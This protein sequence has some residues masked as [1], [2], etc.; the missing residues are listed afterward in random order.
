MPLADTLRRRLRAARGL[1]DCDLLIRNVRYLDVFS[2]AFVEGDVA[3]TSL[4][5]RFPDLALAGT[6]TIRARFTLR[7]RDHLP[8]SL[9]RPR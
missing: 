1:D 3:I 6:P 2:C 4:L 7:G 9:G 5:T 8:V